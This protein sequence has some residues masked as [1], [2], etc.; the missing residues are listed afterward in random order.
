MSQESQTHSKNLI[1]CIALL[2]L[3]ALISTANADNRLLDLPGEYCMVRYTPGTLARASSVQGWLDGMALDFSSWSKRPT[4][5]AAILIDREQWKTMEITQP[6]GLPASLGGGRIA[7]PAYG[8][9]GTVTRWRKLLGGALPVSS[10]STFQ[11]SAEEAASLLAADHLGQ[12]EIARQ[13]VPIAGL[14]PQE[15]WITEVLAHLTVISAMGNYNR[16]SQSDLALYY[17]QLGLVPTGTLD[18]YQDGLAFP[19]WLAFQARFFRAAES[20]AKVERRPMKALTKLENKNDGRLDA[21]IMF[22]TYPDLPGLLAN[23]VSSAPV[24]PTYATSEE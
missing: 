19:Q 20:I 8:D 18:S 13:L 11:G 14:H 2:L 5:L 3:V 7:L 24:Q 1:F 6:Y 9:E 16:A 12:L 23:P 17:Q 4:Y 10:E 22:S 15:S 21:A